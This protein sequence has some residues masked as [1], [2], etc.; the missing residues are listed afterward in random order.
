[1]R[2]NAIVPGVMMYS[3]CQ[4]YNLWVF[5]CVWCPKCVSGFLGHV[6]QLSPGLESI[7]DIVTYGQC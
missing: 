7:H 5:S 4:P 2:V 3:E 1:V 6:V